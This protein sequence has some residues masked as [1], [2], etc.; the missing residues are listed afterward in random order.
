M[1]RHF[2]C[3]ACG[4]CCFGQLPLSLTDAFKHAERFPLAL[5]WTPLRQGSK[6]YP[7]VSHLGVT[8]KISG[9]KEIAALIVPTAY[10]PPSFPC[11]ALRGDNLC[12]IHEEK[13]SRCK[14]MPFYPYREEQYQAELLTPRKGWACDISAAAP[15]VFQ[16]KKIIM[17]KKFDQE[18]LELEEQIPTIRKFAEYVFKYTPMMVDTLT[19]ESNKATPGQIITSL[20]TFLTA[21]RNPNKKIIARQQLTI[22]QEF[23]EK[24]AGKKELVEYH[25]HYTAWA[26]E[27]EFLSKMP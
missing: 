10:I 4:K 1:A 9:R 2:A 20:S 19:R 14:S 24:A 16:D 8:V 3:T 11:P 21:T 18:R 6:D 5:I 12:G 25:R 7:L 22:L 15:V 27:M 17:G 26:T 23:A 13:P